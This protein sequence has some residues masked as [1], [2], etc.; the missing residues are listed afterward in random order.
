M[1]DL[2]LKI[3][4]IEEAVSATYGKYN[5][6]N[7]FYEITKLAIERGDLVKLLSAD[8]AYIYNKN[9]EL[10]LAPI[11]SLSFSEEP[12]NISSIMSELEMIYIKAQDPNKIKEAFVSAFIQ[13]TLGTP[14]Q[15]YFAALIFT[16]LC[17]SIADESCAFYNYET[18]EQLDDQ[19][20]PHLVM[21][22]A[23]S[24][25]D[26]KSVRIY[27]CKNNQDGVLGHCRNCSNRLAEQGILGFVME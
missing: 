13:M 23:T 1:D 27:D 7:K 4:E 15:I 24:D 26:L 12:I 8:Q 6:T 11:S 17:E 21:G 5:V 10:W 16:W 25:V 20:R 2:K 9:G 18:I 14:K 22:I 3:T 19:L